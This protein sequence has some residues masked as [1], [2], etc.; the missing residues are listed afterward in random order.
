MYPRLNLQNNLLGGV[1]AFVRLRVPLVLA[2]RK[3]LVG[4]SRLRNLRFP[5]FVRKQYAPAVG[6]EKVLGSSAY[7]DGSI[8]DPSK[9]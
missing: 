9:D 2:I 1:V 3:T 8:A 7:L 6:R 4:K 5:S